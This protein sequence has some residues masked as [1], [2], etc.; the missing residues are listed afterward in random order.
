MLFITSY[1]IPAFF[2]IGQVT[3]VLLAIVTLVDVW[4]LYRSGVSIEGKRLMEERFSIGEENKVRMDIKNDYEFPVSCTIIDE[5][6]FQFQKRNVQQGIKI[7]AQSNHLIDYSLVPQERGEY[8][9]GNIN[10]YVQGPL[11]LGKRRYRIACSQ[12]IKVYP[13]FIQMKKY[14]LLAQ[15]T[16]L[17]EAGVKKLRRL[18]HS[19][20]FEQIKQYVSGEDYRT[21]NWR[22]TARNGD[23]M[24]NNFSDERSQ[25][26]YCVI[27]KGRI[28]KMPFKGMTM[29]DYAINASLVIS[30]VALQKH[31]KAGLITFAERLDTF[32]L[33]DKKSVQINQILESLYQQ[34][35]NF[36]EPDFEKLFSAI[37]NRIT[38]RSLIILFTNFETIESL[39]RELPT[40]KKLAHYHLLIV[41]F[42][43]NTELTELTD[44]K[45]NDLEGIYMKTIGEQFK[46]EKNLIAKELKMH[47]IIS[48]LSAPEH[49]TVSSL[50]KYLEL[51]KRQLI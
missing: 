45:A 42:F 21:I 3:L 41:V 51:K 19:M 6:P 26:V 22:A 20:E 15:G 33:A 14:Q 49:L 30:K 31:D 38:H 18:G 50:N 47:G 2:I 8:G 46:N 39:R 32:L 23:L 17:L 10:I 40:L 36:S 7:K 34:K 1:Y 29:L 9:F 13:S 5:I 16:H 12:T 28:M 24:V 27:N 35:T 4:L 48:V 44:R 25:Q 11:K 37:R 43:E